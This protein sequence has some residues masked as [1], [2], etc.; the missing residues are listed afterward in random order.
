MSFEVEADAY[1]RF[2][3]RYSS[4]LAGPFADLAEIRFGQRV[5]DVGCGPGALTGELV[6]RVGAASVSAVDPSE[7]FVAAARLRYP[8]VDVE[9]GAGGAA[10]VR[11]RG[12][13][14]DPGATRR[15]LHVR[16]RGRDRGDE[17]CHPERRNRGGVC[18][19]I[20]VAAVAR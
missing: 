17:A 9:Q 5:L 19:G 8:G 18:R 7:S 20:S 4:L 14:C 10:S 13:R 2:M 1:D 6:V 15:P 12:L 3:G 16:P 11:G